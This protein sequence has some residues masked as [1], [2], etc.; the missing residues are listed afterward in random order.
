V[1][2][3]VWEELPDK[4]RKKCKHAVPLNSS[5]SDIF[6]PNGAVSQFIS[7]YLGFYQRIENLLPG[8]RPKADRALREE[9][10]EEKT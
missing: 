9:N 7:L 2:S 3:A 5:M 8:E 10:A 1:V 6:P 4:P